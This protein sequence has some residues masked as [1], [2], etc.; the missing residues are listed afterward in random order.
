[1]KKRSEKI[2]ILGMER[3]DYGKKIVQTLSGKLTLEY[4]R[5]FTRT[6][7]FNMIRCAEV[8]PDR[9]IVHALSGQLSW[10]HFREII[11]LENNLKRDFY[12]EMCRMERW[13]TRT[14]Q[15][16]IQSM[17][18]ERTA[19]SKKSENLI[20]QELATLRE[21][22]R[23]TA[24]QSRRGTR[25]TRIARI[26]TDLRVSASSAQ[27]AFYRNPSAFIRVHLRLIFVSVRISSLFSRYFFP[28]SFI[29]QSTWRS[30]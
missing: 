30:L 3:A 11:Y 14:L 26:I 19:L 1:M 24:P 13:S 6:N 28:G 4:G 18:Y 7:L 15:T 17:L 9:E 23:E 2:E 25:M 29:N 10:T 22:D 27:S 12:A 16:K 21:E 8:F 20:K 5:G